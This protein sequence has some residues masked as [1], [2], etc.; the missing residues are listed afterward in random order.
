MKKPKKTLTVLPCVLLD[1]LKANADNLAYHIRENPEMHCTMDWVDELE[2]TCLL[3]DKCIYELD[4][5]A[6]E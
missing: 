6:P 2:Q 1:V 4:C 3:I 5:R